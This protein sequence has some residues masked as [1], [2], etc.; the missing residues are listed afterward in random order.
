MG[1]CGGCWIILVGCEG[2]GAGGGR[3]KSRRHKSLRDEGGFRED[4]S[5]V[6]LS[7]FWE[8]RE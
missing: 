5:A 7:V 2:G 3:D 1:R 8:S 6:Q 4:R